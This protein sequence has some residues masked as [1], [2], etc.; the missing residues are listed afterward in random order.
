MTVGNELW[1]PA[2]ARGERGLKL[3]QQSLSLISWL[4]VRLTSLWPVSQ[5]LLIAQNKSSGEMGVSKGLI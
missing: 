2:G 4:A 1:R 3:L 5:V